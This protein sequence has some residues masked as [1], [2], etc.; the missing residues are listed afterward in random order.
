MCRCL[1][2]S[3]SSSF[4]FLVHTSD[5]IPNSTGWN[6]A[7]A[8]EEVDCLFHWK[9]QSLMYFL[10]WLLQ[11]YFLSQDGTF[12]P[13]TFV[14]Q[15]SDLESPGARHWV[16]TRSPDHMFGFY[17]KL[18]SLTKSLGHFHRCKWWKRQCQWTKG[19]V[20]GTLTVFMLELLQSPFLF[21][22]SA[23]SG[24]LIQ[25][26]CFSVLTEMDEDE[27]EDKEE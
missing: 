4:S 22:F 10:L 23:K 16:I 11:G 3:T 21:L 17:I 18:D 26:V 5:K 27:D 1:W 7:T 14:G 24:I 8:C 6:T 2:G 12:W 9:L 25:K 13:H 19:R 15:F 20:E